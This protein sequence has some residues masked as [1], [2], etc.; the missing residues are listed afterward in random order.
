MLDKYTLVGF[1]IGSSIEYV[2]A[3]TN[4]IIKKGIGFILPLLAKYNIKGVNVKITISFEVK[5]VKIDINKYNE[6][7]SVY[8]LDLNLLI[9]L[10]ATNEKNPASSKAIEIK[11]TDI[12]KTKIFNGFNFEFVNKI[13]INSFFSNSG[14]I[15]NIKAINNTGK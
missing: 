7:K 11:D 1:P 14:N 8:W 10:I 2:F 12:N 6:K 13:S 4:S 3:A 9:N 5:I 15:N